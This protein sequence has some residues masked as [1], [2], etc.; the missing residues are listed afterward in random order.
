MLSEIDGDP[1]TPLA[2][3]LDE[4]VREAA[5]VLDHVAVHA[6]AGDLDAGRERAEISD[7]DRQRLERDRQDVGLDRRDD[8]EERVGVAG[9]SRGGPVHE[10]RGEHDL[11]PA[12]V[13]PA[14]GLRDP[15]GERLHLFGRTR[16]VGHDAP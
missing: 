1:E 9:V 6:H 11:E 4:P 10:P 2:T 8:L 16:H 13:A 7:I 12:D 14:D 5:L 3:D 15:M